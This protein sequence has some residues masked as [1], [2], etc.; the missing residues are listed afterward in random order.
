MFSVLLITLLF[1]SLTRSKTIV[2]P[3]YPKRHALPRSAPQELPIPAICYATTV[4]KQKFVFLLYIK[5]QKLQILQ[6][7][8]Q[9]SKLLRKT[10]S[11]RTQNVCQC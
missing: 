4:H 3:N 6:T 5:Y 10:Q 2:I 7:F 9:N 11:L 8:Q 1:W